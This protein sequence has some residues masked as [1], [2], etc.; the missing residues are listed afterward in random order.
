MS[1]GEIVDF[2]MP[3]SQ[4]STEAIVLV[5]NNNKLIPILLDE[6]QRGL[7]K[8][9]YHIGKRVAIGY[10]NGKWHLGIPRPVQAVTEPIKNP[11]AYNDLP[12]EDTE[13]YLRTVEKEFSEDV[14][15][16]LD[17]IGLL[18]LKV[19]KKQPGVVP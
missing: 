14:D 9:K 7:I 10:Y 5:K 2:V 16:I 12:E 18:H 15:H 1:V 3:F 11:P 17:N 13:V 8:D 4:Y 19:D 6:R